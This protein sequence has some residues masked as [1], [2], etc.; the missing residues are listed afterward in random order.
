MKNLNQIMIFKKIMKIL[1]KIL[2]KIIKDH[3]ELKSNHDL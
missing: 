1:K 3:E 2:K